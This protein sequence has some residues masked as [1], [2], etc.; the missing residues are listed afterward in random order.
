MD[1]GGTGTGS[2]RSSNASQPYRTFV[3]DVVE[4]GSRNFSIL[5]VPASTVMLQLVVET[6]YRRA[7]LAALSGKGSFVDTIIHFVPF[8]P[9][10]LALCG[11]FFILR[12][13]ESIV[14]H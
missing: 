3:V 5:K 6:T 13:H 1:K 10:N 8:C 7:L 2:D 9:M 11:W 4:E 12:L 14:H